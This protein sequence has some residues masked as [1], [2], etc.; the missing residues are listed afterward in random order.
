MTL[1]ELK[2]EAKKQGYRLVKIPERITLL[3]CPVC[4]SK[5]TSQW[6]G[7][8]GRFYR[9]DNCNFAG[10]SAKTIREARKKWND[11]VAKYKEENNEQNL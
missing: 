9:C 2:V 6:Y 11:A 10:S 8:F 1:D 3:S 7:Y 4:G 5:K